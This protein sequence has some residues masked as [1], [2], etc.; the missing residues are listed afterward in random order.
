ML[1]LSSH[2]SLTLLSSHFED[3][4]T[5]ADAYTAVAKECV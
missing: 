4:Y 2:T 1:L 3:A 5:V